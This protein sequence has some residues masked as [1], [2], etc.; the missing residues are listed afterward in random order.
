VGQAPPLLKTIRQPNHRGRVTQPREV[1]IVIRRAAEREQAALLEQQ[2]RQERQQQ[3]QQVSGLPPLSGEDTPTRVMGEGGDPS[4]L[5]TEEP[6][7]LQMLAHP[8]R[9]QRDKKPPRYLV[10][11]HVGHMEMSPQRI[12]T[13]SMGKNFKPQLQNSPGSTGLIQRQQPPDQ[14]SQLNNRYPAL[15]GNVGRGRCGYPI[16][17]TG[18]E[19]PQE[20]EDKATSLIPA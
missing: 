5:A 4:T 16:P 13:P 8:G 10:D 3:Q 15:S 1:E 11:F 19:P 9:S 17:M 18:L 7:A 12:G 20:K 6:L 2:Q 14:H